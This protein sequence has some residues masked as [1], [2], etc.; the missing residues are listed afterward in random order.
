MLEKREA[1]EK[2]FSEE[3]SFR[4]SKKRFTA[5]FPFFTLFSS[6]VIHCST[7]IGRMYFVLSLLF[8]VLCFVKVLPTPPI[9]KHTHLSVHQHRHARTCAVHCST[10]WRIFMYLLIILMLAGW[11]A[12]SLLLTFSLLSLRSSPHSLT[13]S[14][15]IT[16]FLP[17]PLRLLCLSHIHSLPLTLPPVIQCTGWEDSA[18]QWAS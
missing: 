12:I 16:R 15:S 3:V 7:F 8:A 17:H 11:I 6:Y 4:M 5:F 2:A 1:E 13:N 14:L 10:L 18:Q 9:P